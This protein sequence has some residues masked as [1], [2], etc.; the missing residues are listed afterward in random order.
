VLDTATR[1]RLAHASA[2][3]AGVA[4]VGAGLGL[5]G[6]AWRQADELRFPGDPMSDAVSMLLGTAWATTWWTAA[7]GCL[8][9]FAG[10]VVA[11][12]NDGMGWL[13]IA[14]GL[15]PLIL[16][17]GL[18]GHANGAD[19]RLLALGLDA[20][21]VGAAGT[22]IGTL[23]VIVLIGR[24][25]LDRLVPAFSPVAIGSVVALVVTGAAAGWREIGSISGYWQTE[26][27][28]LLLL[29]LGIFGVVAVLG[30]VNWR[31]FTPR[32]G[33]PDGDR[34]MGRSATL[35]FLLGQVV[36]VVTAILVRTSP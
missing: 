18:T 1:E 3:I 32:L 7:G 20:V 11:R 2:R 28:R 14:V 10:A 24:P 13:L 34:A 5:L 23:G 31:R 6:V 30:A 26:Y 9:L 35:E 21:H 8:V 16:F 22:W 33:S 29:K 4:A 17:P 19:P 36:L 15:M 25:W 12:R 27:G